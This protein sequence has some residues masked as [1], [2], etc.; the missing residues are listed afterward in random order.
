METRGGVERARGPA[1]KRAYYDSTWLLSEARRG[2][3]SAGANNSHPPLRVGP[4]GGLPPRGQRAAPAARL[5]TCMGNS[6]ME[7]CV[8]QARVGMLA[9]ALTILIGRLRPDAGAAGRPALLLLVVEDG[10][11]ADEYLVL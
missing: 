5:R 10:W 1:P 3:A 8:Q 11:L 9:S 4:Y 6:I 2:K 7:K